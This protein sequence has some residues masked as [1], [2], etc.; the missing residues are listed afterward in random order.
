MPDLEGSGTVKAIHHVGGV[1]FEK[2]G[3]LFQAEGYLKTLSGK[4]NLMAT[5]VSDGVGNVIVY[6]PH[7]GDEYAR[8]ADFFIQKR[9]GWFNHM[10]G[11]SL[12]FNGEKIDELVDN[13][14][15]PGYNHRLHRIKLT[16]MVTWKNWSLTGSWQWESGLPVVNLAGNQDL[17]DIQR[18]TP[19]SQVD[20][21]LVKSWRTAHMHTKAGVSLLNLLNRRNIVEVDYLRFSSGQGSLSVRSDISAL[22]ITPVFFVS[23]RIF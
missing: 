10:A 1:T 15:F 13:E 20:M 12:S 2:N 11:Y 14:W 22:E 23:V 9:H 8:G 4:I 21:A 17:W 7:E 19:F 5:T 16:E 6:A 3:W 18:T